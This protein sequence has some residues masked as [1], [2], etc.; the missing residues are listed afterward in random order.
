MSGAHNLATG[1]I[2]EG[3]KGEEY[4]KELYAEFSPEH[5]ANEGSKEDNAKE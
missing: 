2:P 1:E 4:K 3:T 5:L